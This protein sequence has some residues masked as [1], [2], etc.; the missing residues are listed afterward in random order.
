MIGVGSSAESLIIGRAP[1]V[2]VVLVHK[3]KLYSSHLCV[4]DATFVSSS[5]ANFLPRGSAACVHA[6]PPLDVFAVH[7]AATAGVALNNY[8]SDYPSNT[9][10]N[11]AATGDTLLGAIDALTVPT[12]LETPTELEL[13]PRRRGDRRLKAQARALLRL[14][15][16]PTPPEPS[17]L[18][19]EVHEVCPT[20]LRES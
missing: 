6:T 9:P 13:P 8:P 16:A 15:A 1:I 11:D 14:A 12:S 18:T 17:V 3:A 10:S 5:S 19:F 2:V 4:F 20:T 7:R